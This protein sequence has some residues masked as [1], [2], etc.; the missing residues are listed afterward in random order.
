MRS[1]PKVEEDADV[2]DMANI[3]K[4]EPS[5]KDE[6]CHDKKAFDTPSLSYD[7]EALK[8]KASSSPR[9]KRQLESLEKPIT[10]KTTKKVRFAEPAQEEKNRT[11]AEWVSRRKVFSD[12]E[13]HS[14]LDVV[15]QEEEG[16]VENRARIR[17]GKLLL[18]CSRCKE[19]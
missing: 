18:S 19:A 4:E 10:S 13:P 17:L 3:D 1:Q 14:L 15:A 16:E 5:P 2:L 8:S 7:L 6:G 12:A 11:F 9:E